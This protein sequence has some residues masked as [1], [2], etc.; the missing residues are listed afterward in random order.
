MQKSFSFSLAYVLLI[1][2]GQYVMKERRGYNLR[3]PLALW[4]FSLAL[5]SILGIMRTG[6]YMRFRLSTS[7]FKQ[8]VCD[9]GFYTGP[10]CKFWAF[11]FVMSKVL[12]LGDT[13]FIVLR[14]QK[15]LFLHWY[16]HITVLMYSWYAYKDMVAGGGWFMTMNY[17][18]HAF[19][20]SYYTVRAAGLKVP[21]SLAMVITFTQIL[22]MVMGTTVTILAYSW[23]QDENCYTSWRQIFWSAMMYL[24]YLVLFCQ[25]FREAY[26]RGRGKTKGD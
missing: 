8:S 15:L 14:K 16:H 13:V 24:S 25:F 3:M 5:F 6:E 1:F 20:Y 9:R 19:M 11:L 17:G 22:Q 26:F 10:I 4:S 21:R 23:M 18:V 2:G 7:G 12:E